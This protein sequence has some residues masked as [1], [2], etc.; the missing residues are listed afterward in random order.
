MTLFRN[1]FPGDEL[2]GMAKLLIERGIDLSHKNMEGN[3][4]IM[5]LITSGY[6]NNLISKIAKL[7]IEEDIDIYLQNN[8]R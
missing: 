4:A 8:E 1:K 3:N 7:L 2:L 6:A 5:Q